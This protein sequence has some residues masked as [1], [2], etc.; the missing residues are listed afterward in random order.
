VERD[1]R[2]FIGAR[3]EWPSYAEF[4]ANGQRSLRD[5]ITR[6][7]GARTWARRIGVAYPERPPGYAPRWTE[8][9]IHDELAS[10]LAGRDTWPSYQEFESAGR[11]PLRQALAR[12]GGSERWA[13]EFGIRRATLREGSHRV[14]G[15][16]RLEDEIAPLVRALGRWPTKSEFRRAGLASALNAVHAHRGV[17]WW[18]ARLGVSSTPTAKPFPNRRFWTDDRIEAELTQFCAHRDA[19]PTAREFELAGHGRVYRAA[20][21]RGGI[22]HWRARLGFAPGSSQPPPNREERL[23]PLAHEARFTLLLRV[24]ETSIRSSLSVVRAG[25]TRGPRLVRG[26]A[27]AALGDARS[28]R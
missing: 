3:S 10:F 18:R 1:L 26:V 4:V 15:D 19:W 5:A 17:N 23:Q 7:G 14:W 25:V 9:R 13:A 6:T 16:Q 27:G 12:S 11:R 21:T 24:A 22:A 8:Q 2:R 20:G 28:R